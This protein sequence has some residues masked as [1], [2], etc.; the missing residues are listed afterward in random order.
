MIA[1]GG[2]VYLCGQQE[3]P[4]EV[5]QAAFHH[6]IGVHTPSD[7]ADIDAVAL[8]LECRRPRYHP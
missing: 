1:V 3:L 4:V 2:A 8:E 6:R 5:L 7:L